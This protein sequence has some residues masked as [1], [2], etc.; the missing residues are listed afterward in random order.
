MRRAQDSRFVVDL[1]GAS[2][3]AMILS[4][5]CRKKTGD[6]RLG[7]SP[8]QNLHKDYSRDERG[9]LRVFSLGSMRVQQ[10]MC[11]LQHTLF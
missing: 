7:K 11:W 4:R 1:L 2:C 10:Q 8:G 3:S 9:W 5:L 6:R